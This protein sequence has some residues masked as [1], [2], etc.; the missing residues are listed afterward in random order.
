[1]NRMESG[2]PSMSAPLKRAVPDRGHFSL[3]LTLFPARTTIIQQ[4]SAPHFQD[5][6]ISAPVL[7][8]GAIPSPGN[9]HI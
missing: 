4:K 3:R 5:L 1:M 7:Q 6:L 8:S 2:N 9:V